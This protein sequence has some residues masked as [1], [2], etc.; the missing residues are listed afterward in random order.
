MPA[1]LLST[2]QMSDPGSE[3]PAGFEYQWHIAARM[4][5][6]MLADKEVEYVVCEFHEDVVQIRRGLHLELVQVKKRESG[7]WTLPSLVR[8]ERGQQQGILGKLFG[9]LQKGKDVRRLVLLGY[10]RV[11]GDGE[12]SLPELIALLNLPNEGHDR[13]WE[14]NIRRY[15][16]FLSDELVSQGI[17]PDTIS[18]GIELLEVDFSSPHPDAIEIQNQNLLDET[19][20]QMWKVELSMPEVS[21]VYQD[22]HRRV[23]KVSC[24]PKQPWQ[25]KAISR[26][27]II[28][29]VS[30]RVKEYAPAASRRESL[31][32]QDKMTSAGM[33]QK[34]IY[35]LQKRLDAMQLR[36]EL[37]IEAPQWEDFRTEI[38]VKWREFRA[39]N[40]KVQGPSLWQSLRSILSDLGQVWA[41][42][43]SRLGSDFAEGIFF[44]MTGTCEAEWRAGS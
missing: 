42:Q 16:H 4:C 36:F 1:R 24:K 43:D 31:T 34:V 22:I 19:L 12:C 14:N 6:Q 18:K 17:D 40:P 35:A 7:N 26:Q 5:I 25:L 38:D 8:P 30:S 13:G 10:G 9:Q 41:E 32:T 44:D 29:L 11:S 2:P 28:D 39:G 20:R 33:G 21:T 15:V 3:A 23:Q 27:E 37:D